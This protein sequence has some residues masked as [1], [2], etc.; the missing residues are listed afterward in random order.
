VNYKGIHVAQDP[1]E[2]ST[3]DVEVYYSPVFP[4]NWI[5]VTLN[6]RQSL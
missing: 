5:I 6:L 1:N 4:L 2:P 3:V